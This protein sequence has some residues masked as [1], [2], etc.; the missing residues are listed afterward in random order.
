M[1]LV[2]RIL[3]PEQRPFVRRVW[4]FVREE[5][6]LYVAAAGFEVL[7]LGTVVLYPQ[8]IR[9]IIDDGIQAGSLE[10]IHSLA[11][12]MAGVLCLQAVATYQRTSLF[13]IGSHRVVSHMRI[14]VF[15]NLL[16]QELAFFDGRNAGELASRLSADAGRIG[17][18]TRDLL[19]SLI[20]SG[21]VGATAT[22]LMIYTSPKLSLVVALAAPVIWGVTNALGRS[23]RTHSARTQDTAARVL[24]TALESISG[25]LAVR[26]YGAEQAEIERY[27]GETESWKE[28][29]KVQ[30]NVGAVLR[31]ANE[32]LAEGAILLALWLGG[33]LIVSGQLTPGSVVTFVLYAGMVMGALRDM[34]RA[35]AELLRVQGATE[36]VFKLGERESRMADVGGLVPDRT[37]GELTLEDVHFA[38]PSRRDSAALR[39]LDLRIQPGE[40]VAIVGASGSG[41]STITRLMTR[42]YDPDRGRV[43]LD[44]RD[45]R[46]LDPRYVRERIALVPADAAIFARS[47]SDNIR[48]GRSQPSEQRVEEAARLAATEGFVRE[49]PQG[50]QTGAGD[51]GRLLSS[52]QRQRIAIARG[53]LAEPPVLILDEATAALDAE[54]EQ[55]VREAL[56]ELPQHPTL[57][58]VSHRLSTVVDADRVVLVED[59]RVVAEGTHEALLSTQ[60]GYRDLMEKQLVRS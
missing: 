22:A 41:K 15:R 20:H 47:L 53:V 51:Q 4:G 21:L 43:L 17:V 6:R 52:G 12:G 26:S 24:S 28:T 34:S 42:I 54:T 40:V 30:A 49:L 33:S 39:G 31:A 14:W 16:R 55:I 23:M 19:P 32:W 35:S 8:L 44:G 58:I 29:I 50:L 5:R 38:Y 2:D 57:V 13:A 9:M 59:G 48:L 60:Q 3:S 18:L 56:R 36:E 37:R 45:L 10:R 1:A 7:S 25:M 27:E 46:A 11:L